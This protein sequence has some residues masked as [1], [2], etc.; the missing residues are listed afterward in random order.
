MEVGYFRS[1]AEDFYKGH[2]ENV[3]KKPSGEMTS[4]EFSRLSSLTGE[5]KTEDYIQP[6]YKESYRLAIDRLVK[7]GRDSYHEFLKGENLGTFL[8][9]REIVHIV[10]NAEH[11]QPEN[12]IND[13]TGAPDPS[14]DNQSSSGT[15]WPVHSDVK[16]PDLDLGWPKVMHENLHTSI[17]LLFHPPRLNNPTIKEVIR[18]QIQ[19]ARQ[20]IGI[21]MD[22]FTDVDIF[23]EVV[24]A[25][26]RGVS[27]YVLLDHSNLK[28]FLKM[29]EG[30]KVNLEHLR[31]MRV[32]TLKGP[33]YLCQSGAK[34]HGTMEQKFLLI[35]CH[36]AI[37]GSYSFAWSFEKIHL[38]MVQVITGHLVKSYDEEFRTL[39]AHS[40]VPPELECVFNIKGLQEQQMTPKSHSA[41]QL[42]QNNQMKYIGIRNLNEEGNMVG[43]L[44]E[45]H[46]NL[47]HQMP[48]FSQM[49][50]EFNMLKRHSYAGERQDGHTP[51]NIRPRG[52]NWNITKDT[53]YGPN[54]YSMDN[55][56]HTPQ[57]YRGL[58]MRQSYNGIDKQALCM[59]Q[60][61]PTLENTSKAFMRTW[62]IDSYLKHPE[63]QATEAFD[64][65][66]QFE[67]PDK[68]SAFMQ[69][70]MRSSLVLR[71][72]MPEQMKPNRHM[73]NM[74]AN[75][76]LSA[77]HNSFLHYSSMQWDPAA[78]AGNR[79]NPSEFM[80]KK[81]SL[82][83]LDDFQDTSGNGPGGN[84]YYP[85]Y[86][87]LGR[88]KHGQ[89][90][91]NPDILTDGWHKRHSVA[92]PRS[93]TEHTHEY[94]GQ[95]YEN[96]ARTQVNKSTA[97][98]S[99]QVGGYRSN[100]N[101]DQ[102]SISHYD[103]KSFP[104]DPTNSFWQEPPSRAVSAAALDLKN[105][106]LTKKSIN[107]QQ[108]PKN[109]SKKIQP[110]LNIQGK[111]E[112]SIKSN[113]TPSLNSDDSTNTITAEDEE[114]TT[115]SETE[116]PQIKHQTTSSVKFA[117]K[118]SK[119]RFKTE[120]PQ[121]SRQNSLT[122]S[123]TWKKP[124]ILE[125]KSK[126]AA[127]NH[128]YSKEESFFSFEKKSAL[129]GSLRRSQSQDKSKSYSKGDAAVEH[130]V[131]RSVR[132]HSENKLGKFFQRMGSLIHK[133][134]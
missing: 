89:I 106:D 128:Q 13:I 116:N 93:N 102:R 80:S 24:D 71:S 134:K 56:L 105:K 110:L 61:I 33:Q 117:S 51:H 79:L 98:L 75:V 30:Q 114:T 130:N 39:Y 40:T 31:K 27:V 50:S 78:A 121:I 14:N 42:G 132:G 104:K 7:D 34:F 84:F 59:Q 96:A 64:Y 131:S 122:K 4:P 108:N 5:I 20:V 9:E 70:R 45:N 11:L 129:P 36:T 29:A 115:S 85:M 67:T 74:S 47:H 87:S 94:S 101:E 18:K 3:L 28:D 109:S 107:A 8:S 119:P 12:N 88:P 44:F 90:M 55:Y 65:L 124:S 120:E 49:E 81:Q 46:I 97:E 103:V 32:R 19:D 35:D 26:L 133:S 125:K 86:V 48:Q 91:T 113:E 15:Y 16:T 95:V 1:N 123:P 10:D 100:L 58:N 23:K 52:S 99:S 63:V 22:R 53:R 92:D 112:N 54:D 118:F 72:T 25:S 43:P 6:H 77:A 17:H 62:R 66:D 38:S 83:Q 127:E 126:P 2:Y 76:G 57:N 60:N 111:N 41:S 73:N 21:V 69:G 82:Q 37:F 68:T